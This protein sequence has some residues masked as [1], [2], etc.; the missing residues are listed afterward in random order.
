MAQ[1]ISDSHHEMF[2]GG[3][4]VYLEHLPNEKQSTPVNRDIYGKV[5][6]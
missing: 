2:M 4:V 5:M 3:G 1:D 6:Q